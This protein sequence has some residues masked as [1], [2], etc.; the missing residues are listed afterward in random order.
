VVQRG[1]RMAARTAV[2]APDG[3]GARLAV[4]MEEEQQPVVD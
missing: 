4:L 3:G 2:E 1:Q